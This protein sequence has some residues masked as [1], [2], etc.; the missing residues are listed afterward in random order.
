MSK[1][2]LTFVLCG[3]L[4]ACAISPAE[5]AE[6]SNDAV[7]SST[8]PNVYKGGTGPKGGMGAGATGDKGKEDKAGK[9][10]DDKSCPSTPTDFAGACKQLLAIVQA[11]ID[12]AFMGG[13]QSQLPAL[14]EKSSLIWNACNYSA[15]DPVKPTDPPKPTDPC[16]QALQDL[17]LEINAA[18]KAGDNALVGALKEK[19]S[20]LASSCVPPT[21]PSESCTQTLKDLSLQIDAAAKAGDNALVA[22][23]K[24]KYSALASS[25]APPSN[26]N[27]E[28]AQTL[29]TLQIEI[30]A[31]IKSGASELVVALKEKYASVSAYCANS[32]SGNPLP[33]KK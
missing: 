31:A 8:K 22:A 26:P 6:S 25:C 14:K 27:D 13:D 28:C 20:A 16:A 32:G 4:G 21:T 10:A 12:A 15:P 23:L 29:K 33:E 2:W 3:T 1:Y 19:Y 30:E 9:G 11:D 17:E 18:A 7:S 5:E 24:E